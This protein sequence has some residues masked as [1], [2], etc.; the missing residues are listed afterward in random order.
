MSNNGHEPA[1][2][3]TDEMV[4]A[5]PG[6]QY[7]SR[8]WWPGLSKREVFAGLA[9]QGMLSCQ[10]FMNDMIARGASASKE[11]AFTDLARWA[12]KQADAMVAEAAKEKP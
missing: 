2:A 3:P 1:F 10:D 7:E 12:F 5:F 11:A 4:N 6:R 9:M 8:H